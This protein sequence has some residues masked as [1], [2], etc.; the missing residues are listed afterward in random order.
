MVFILPLSLSLW[1]PPEVKRDD[2]PPNRK[3][4]RVRRRR[5][6]PVRVGAQV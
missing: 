1:R 4:P 5:G 6:A 3:R 2:Y